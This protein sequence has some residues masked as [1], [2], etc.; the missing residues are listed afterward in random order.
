[1][2]PY[3]AK[4]ISGVDERNSGLQGSLAVAFRIADVQ[5]GW[6][7]I[8]AYNLFYIFSFSAVDSP[9]ALEIG[10]VILQAVYPEKGVDITFLAVADDT[11]EIVLGKFFEDRQKIRIEGSAAF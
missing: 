6:D 10:E 7:M 8:A 1:M 3:G 4:S 2:N 5:S 9:K 11:E